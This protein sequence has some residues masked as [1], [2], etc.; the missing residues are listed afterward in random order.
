[1]LNSYTVNTAT[2]KRLISKQFFALLLLFRLL[3]DIMD[4]G[5]HMRRLV[6]VTDSCVKQTEYVIILRTKYLNRGVI[7]TRNLTRA[8][9]TFYNAIEEWAWSG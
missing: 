4:I 9:S 3:Q 6:H 1:M 5:T 8:T 7:S 2:N